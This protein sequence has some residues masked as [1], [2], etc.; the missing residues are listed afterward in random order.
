MTDVALRD[1]AGSGGGLELV[2]AFDERALAIAGMAASPNTRRAY[3]TAYRAF[4][5]FLRVR[6]GEAS[7]ETGTTVQTG[8]NGEAR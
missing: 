8:E 5:G 6:Y 3:A 1:R 4:A 2:D 7:K